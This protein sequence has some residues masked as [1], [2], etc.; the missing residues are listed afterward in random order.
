MS[1]PFLRAAGAVEAAVPVVEGAVKTFAP[2]VVQ[3]AMQNLPGADATFAPEV[4]QAAREGLGK[5]A[6]TAK[7]VASTIW[8]DLVSHP[9]AFAATEAI[10]SAASGAGHYAAAKMYPNSPAAQAIGAIAGAGVAMSAVAGAR[11]YWRYVALSHYGLRAARA[12]GSGYHDIRAL[13]QGRTDLSA[14]TMNRVAGRLGRAAKGGPAVPPDVSANVPFSPAQKTGASGMLSLEKSVMSSSDELNAGHQAQLAA[15]NAQISQNLHAVP[16]EATPA[17]TPEEARNYLDSLMSARMTSAAMHAD[18]SVA[19]LG[20]SATREDLNVAARM[21]L[22]GAL[23]DAR[24]QERQLYDALPQGASVDIS[25]IAK[26][27]QDIVSTVPKAQTADVSST[28]RRFLDPGSESYLGATNQVRT[29]ETTLGEIR[30]VQ[31]KLRE[32]ARL[33]RSAGKF[34]RARIDDLLANSVT[35]SISKVSG[36]QDVANKVQVATQFSKDLNDRF[37]R[38][39]VGKLLGFAREGGSTVPDTMTL[40]TTVG[41]GGMSG[42]VS[43]DAL[44]QAVDRSGQQP[45]MRGYIEQYLVDGFKRASVRDGKIDPNAADSYLRAN[46]DVLA[47]FPELQRQLVTVRN[48]GQNFLDT[49]R[50]SDPSIS[51]AA[52]YLRAPPGQEVS[53]IFSTSD[54]QGQMQQLHDLVTANP[55]ALG[56][57]KQAFLNQVEK[58]SQ[59]GAVDANGEPFMTGA[60]FARALSD[61]RVQAAAKGLFTDGEMGRLRYVQ[62]D[63]SLL[64][65]IR[66]APA[67]SEGIMGDATGIGT[68]VLAR[69]IGARLGSLAGGKGAGGE[70]QA[71]N[72]G[73]NLMARMTK[74]GIN[75]PATRFISDVIQDPDLFQAATTHVRSLQDAKRVASQMNSWILSVL[76]TY[77]EGQTNPRKAAK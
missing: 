71:A 55:T 61:P 45:A 48:S 30:G 37:T 11:A 47:R 54:P 27:Y 17:A 56:G 20:A 33:S 60:R 22:Q 31:S 23:A 1:I 5:A 10:S 14:A 28:A 57:L 41:K 19:A 12:L 51:A 21:Q 25:Q 18:E 36:P 9:G 38:G 34:N 68:T 66:S 53:R 26:D 75:D 7:G 67:S 58:M 15:V 62:N 40:E 65:Q 42:A 3:S 24:Q 13:N 50:F 39:P 16:Y 59:A 46:R 64:D 77:G 44:L 74:A 49:Q 4:V 76:S 70:I 63:L 2:G 72:I 52:V 69:V 43:T 35:D 6:T 8:N 32:D 29:D 73:S